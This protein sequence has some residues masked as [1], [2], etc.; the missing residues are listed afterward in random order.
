[1]LFC[2]AVFM[3]AVSTMAATSSP[4]AKTSDLPEILL[5]GDSIRIGYCGAVSNALTGKAAAKRLG[6]LVAVRLASEV[7]L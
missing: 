3:F 1:M 6:N 2:L 7:G 4:A 5:V